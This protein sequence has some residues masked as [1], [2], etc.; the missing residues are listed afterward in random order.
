MLGLKTLQSV[1]P[2]A[3]LAKP[4]DPE[5]DAIA[6]AEEPHK[7]AAR[8]PD[9]TEDEVTMLVIQPPKHLNH[10]QNLRFESEEYVNATAPISTGTEEPLLLYYTV[11]GRRAQMQ[12]H[13][14]HTPLCKGVCAE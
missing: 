14:V 1:A 5:S 9:T 4:K 8:T 13:A 3:D 11:A 12:G 10:A 2:L 6:R 7:R